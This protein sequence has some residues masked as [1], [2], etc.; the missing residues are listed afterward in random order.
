MR[1]IVF[2]VLL[3]ALPAAAAAETW[4]C[5]GTDPGWRLRFDATQAEFSFPATTQMDVMQQNQAEGRDWPRALTLVG[6]RD[7]AIVIVEPL[8]CGSDGEQHP[9]RVLVLTQR[10]QTPILLAGCCEAPR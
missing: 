1:A 2:P 8:A 6:D 7:T 10:G 4:R 9:Y 5:A 3:T